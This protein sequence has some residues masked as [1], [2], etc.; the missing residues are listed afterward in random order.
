MR[1]FPM[2]VALLLVGCRVDNSLEKGGDDDNSGG[3][4][5]S[6]LPDCVPE[7]EVC[8]GV[9]NDCD[10]EVDE[11]LD[12]TWYADTDGDGFGDL[13]NTLTACSQP[14]GYVLDTSDCDDANA[15]I[16]PSRVEVCNGLDDD[17]S[18]DVDID[19]PS[20]PG[21]KNGKKKRKR[22]GECVG[23]SKKDN[24]GDCAPCRNDKSHQIC[25]QRRCEKLTEKKVRNV[26]VSH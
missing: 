15:A 4:E 19:D 16:N 10:G 26:K 20:V 13:G 23:C 11:G 5:D 22:C 17:C 3:T 1:R 8:D 2:L 7:E 9:D 14:L 24:C 21:G 6:G 12:Q 25:K 18:G